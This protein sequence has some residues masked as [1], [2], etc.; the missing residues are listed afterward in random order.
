MKE[1]PIASKA[2]ISGRAR[3]QFTQRVG[4]LC[5]GAMLVMLFSGVTT[6]QAVPR[7]EVAENGHAI[8]L[9]SNG[10]SHLLKRVGADQEIQAYRLLNSN[11]VFIAYS[12][13]SSGPGTTMSI[14]GLKPRTERVIGDLGATEDISFSFNPA[15]HAT[16]FNWNHGIY[17]FDIDKAQL[18]PQGNDQSEN[19]KNSLSLLYK[20]GYRCYNPRWLDSSTLSF[21]DQMP[22]GAELKR[23][24]KTP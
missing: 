9:L 2:S 20:C 1:R 12:Y 8:F 13:Y 11:E 17:E 18:I 14:I 19:F 10:R 4:W 5:L 21:I 7:L 16:V 23:T 22:D 24:I 15:S 6:S 3:M